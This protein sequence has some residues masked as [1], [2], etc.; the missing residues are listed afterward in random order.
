MTEQT[1]NNLGGDDSRRNNYQV[2]LLGEKAIGIAQ[3]FYTPDLAHAFWRWRELV[4]CPS[5]KDQ[6]I[7]AKVRGYNVVADEENFSVRIKPVGDIDNNQPYYLTERYAPSDIRNENFKD[8]G[9]GEKTTRYQTGVG[10]TK[11]LLDIW[12]KEEVILSRGLELKLES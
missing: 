4:A 5:F 12:N 9:R 11:D 3:T 1:K 6:A 10:L 2:T 7:L 8:R